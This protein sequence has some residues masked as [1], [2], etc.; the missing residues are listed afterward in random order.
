[1]KNVLLVALFIMFVSPSISAE[2]GGR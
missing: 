2:L 1:M